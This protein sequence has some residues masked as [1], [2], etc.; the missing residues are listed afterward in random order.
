MLR[1]LSLLE[2]WPDLWPT[3]EVECLLDGMWPLQC[4]LVL[5]P[6]NCEAAAYWSSGNPRSVLLAD[7][8]NPFLKK[9]VTGRGPDLWPCLKFLVGI[10]Q[11][12]MF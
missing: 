1:S 2:V 12:S 8:Q 4:E 9:T 5:S 6:Y 11:C 10:P 7:P 3:A